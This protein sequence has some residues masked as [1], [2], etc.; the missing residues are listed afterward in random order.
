M[1]QQQQQQQQQQHTKLPGPHQ[2][3]VSASSSDRGTTVLTRPMAS[4]SGASYRRDRNQ[5]SRAF[6]CPAWAP[7]SCIC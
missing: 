5:I 7:C 6:F 1:Q 3:R 2:L 4:A